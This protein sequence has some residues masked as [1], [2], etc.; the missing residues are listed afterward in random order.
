MLTLALL[1][2]ALS[3]M[4]RRLY[5]LLGQ[6]IADKRDNK[7]FTQQQL[8]DK[9]SLTRTS[10]T[11]IERGRQHIQLHTLYLLAKALSVEVVDLLPAR[12]SVEN[13]GGKKSI[14]LSKE[15]WLKNTILGDV[16]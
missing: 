11:N 4:D 8:A 5:E 16:Q 6:T 3:S 12:K 14:T 15:E 9:V 2:M 13:T 10:I 1:G 7:A